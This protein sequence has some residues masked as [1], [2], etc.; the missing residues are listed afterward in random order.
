[1]CRDAPCRAHSEW[2]NRDT[3]DS[4]AAAQPLSCCQSYGAWGQEA[5]GEDHTQIHALTLMEEALTPTK[6]MGKDSVG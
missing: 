1:M 6:P 5:K 4:S 2:N 3:A